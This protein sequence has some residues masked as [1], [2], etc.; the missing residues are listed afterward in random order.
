MKIL[1]TF[2]VQKIKQ[3]I[4]KYLVQKMKLIRIS[5]VNIDKFGYVTGEFP[6]NT[7]KKCPTI[8]FIAHMDTNSDFSGKNINPIIKENYTDYD[9]ILKKAFFQYWLLGNLSYIN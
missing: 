9:I 8:Y 3:N 5:N 2:Q 7:Q 6:S 4:Q 1:K